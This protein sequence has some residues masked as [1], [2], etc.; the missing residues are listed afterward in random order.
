MFTV[1][2]RDRVRDSLVAMGR[3]DERVVACALV[4]AAARG[5]GDR[6]SDLDLTFGLADGASVAEVLRDWTA[7]I[8]DKFAAVHLFDL[9]FLSSV[10]RVF[11]LPG[12]LQVDLS[13]TPA[14]EFGALGPEFALLFGAA[15][16]RPFVEPPPGRHLFGLS[17]HHALRARICIE[18]GR[19][20]Q[21]EYWIGEA[22]DQG[23][24][25]ACR[26]RGLPAGQGRG[27][28]SLPATVLESFDGTLARS[29][30]PGELVRAL[31]R[32]VHALLSVAGDVPG[33]AGGLEERLRQLTSAPGAAPSTGSTLH[34]PKPSSGEPS[35]RPSCRQLTTSPGAE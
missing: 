15:V 20:W 11:L 24:S 9:P 3:A 35:A 26:V 7:E 13:F 14:A 5:G 18:R 1:E 12:S 32:V 17:V 34:S 25:A 28:D 6:W 33:L 21:A 19:R 27:F 22:R 30:D 8:G 16:E 2:E 31:D 29:L 4:G 10:Y 23:L